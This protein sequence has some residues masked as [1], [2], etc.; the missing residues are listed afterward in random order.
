MLLFRYLLDMNLQEQISRMKSM[1]GLLIENNEYY[2]EILDL[3]SEKGFE[4]MTDDEIDYLKSGGQTKLPIRFKQ[5]DSESKNQLQNLGVEDLKTEEWQDIFQL[6]KIINSNFGNVQYKNSFEGVGFHLNN[7]CH[8]IFNFDKE[9]LNELE[10]LNYSNI[11][12][13]LGSS[14]IE[15]IDDKIYYVIPKNWVNQLDN[16]QKIDDDTSN[17]NNNDNDDFIG[18]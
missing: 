8:L 10:D 5:Y 9:T 6:Q 12:E 1:M 3:Y 13:K 2:D 4:G 16:L 18:L 15:I 14:T 7:F 11:M 17:N